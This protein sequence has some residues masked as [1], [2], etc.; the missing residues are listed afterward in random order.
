MCQ[1]KTK[2]DLRFIM[3]NRKIII[4]NLSKGKI[5]EDASAFL[6]SI[7]ITKF[8][9]DAMSRADISE[10]LRNDFYLY[11]D[12][13][14]N[15][16]TDA[17]SN[18]LSEAR[19]YKLNLTLANQYISQMHESARD[20]IF[21]NVGTIVAFQSGFTD[22]EIISSQ[23][24]EAV[25]TDD[26]M[27]LPKYSAYIKLLIDG[28]PSRPFSV[29]TLAPEPS[30]QKSNRGKIIYNSRER[31]AKNRLFVEGKIAGKSFISR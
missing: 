28:M 8:Y 7:L 10:N 11:I 6:G 3:D 26:I 31:F 30:L 27:F 18:I 4:I 22:A 12:E 23:F 24:G 14:Q 20:A 5:G 25:S 1:P 2:L 17:F 13:F 15:F 19:K 29:K 16:A 9:I 21:G